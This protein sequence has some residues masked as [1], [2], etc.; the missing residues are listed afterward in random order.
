MRNGVL[1]VI[2][3]SY[4]EEKM[5][6]KTSSVIAQILEGEAIDYELLFVN[7]GSK[8]AT[9]PEI[10][11]ACQRNGKVRGLCFSRNFG[12]E[13]AIFAGLEQAKGSCAVVI[14]CDLQHPPEKL[15]QMYRLWQEGYEVVEGVKTDRGTET[16]LHKLCAN[17]FYKIISKLT[18][19]DM[20][21]ASDFKLMDRKVVDV[22][23]AMP[24]RNVFF[25]AL[26]S[27]VGFKSTTVPFEVQERQAGVSKWS[28]WSLVKYAISN[29]TSFS[30]APMQVVTVLG[31]LFFAIALVLGLITIIQWVT[32]RAVEGFTTVIIITLLA[33][34]IIMTSMGVI[35]Y[36]IAKMYEELKGRPK[37][38]IAEIEN[39]PNEEE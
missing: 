25:R 11:L 30:A 35:G 34:S 15:V 38:I 19:I 14:D 3:P 32:G 17:A 13:A 7:D 23:K 33:G 2:I 6:A 22:L 18:K 10:L 21:N 28:S 24:E 39:T 27:W 8:D 4:N 1:S 20:S 26:S 16:G 29:I 9:W 37:Y 31:V 12:K 5:I 36:Y